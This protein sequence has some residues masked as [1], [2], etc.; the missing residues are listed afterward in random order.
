MSYLR[1]RAQ[2]RARAQR[3]AQRQSDTGAYS[4][5]NWNDALQ[6]AWA[7][8][9][10]LLTRYPEGYGVKRR[11]A[12]IAVAS[13]THTLPAEFLSLRSVY[14]RASSGSKPRVT[15][16]ADWNAIF[17]LGVEDGGGTQGQG[18]LWMIEGPG[19]EDDGTTVFPQRLRFFPSLAAGEVLDLIFVTHPPALQEAV[20]VDVIAEPV[21]AAICALARAV[22]VV[23]EDN[24][25]YQ[26]A[27]QALTEAIDLF[28]K[29]HGQRDRTGLMTPAATT[30]PGWVGY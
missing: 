21:E 10:Y 26:R 28:I 15:G 18:D 13:A 3:E 30:V 4:T 8:A 24:S 29:H 19:L 1:T 9:W 27:H 12:T 7:K 17:A 5:T 25:D 16:Q 20:A 2:L 14:R 6:D 11:Q 22:A 23:R